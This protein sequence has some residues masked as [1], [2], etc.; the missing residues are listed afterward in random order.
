MFTRVPVVSVAKIVKSSNNRH[1]KLFAKSRF[2]RQMVLK[3]LHALEKQNLKF[4]EYCSDH[5]TIK[6]K[7]A[8][9][10]KD[11]TNT[12]RTFDTFLNVPIDVRGSQRVR[13]ST[14]IID[15]NVIRKVRK[16]RKVT[17]QQID[18]KPKRLG[19]ICDAYGCMHRFGDPG[20]YLKSVPS[21]PIP[22]NI[23]RTNL[24][25]VDRIR[26][27][28]RMDYRKRILVNLGL[29][30]ID[31]RKDIRFCNHHKVVTK[32]FKVSWYNKHN[33]QNQ[34]ECEMN[35]PIK[36]ISSSVSVNAIRIRRKTKERE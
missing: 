20:T 12:K 19:K 24:K 30:P 23:T 32:K 25:N 11:D 17:E 5:T 9:P 16:T 6:Q 34:I 7:F 3:R 1:R 35:L 13:R 21:R 26:Y 2:K 28:C 22:L 18:E 29:H 8:I 27:Y 4:M 36:R 33:K 14:D 31:G 15:T 10:Y